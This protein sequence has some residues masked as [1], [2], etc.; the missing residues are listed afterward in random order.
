[1]EFDPDTVELRTGV[2]NPSSITLSDDDRKGRLARIVRELHAGRSHAEVAS[3]TGTTE[4][5]VAD[6]IQALLREE[7]LVPA[8]AGESA[9]APYLIARTLGMGMEDRAVPARAM[10][11]APTA[12]GLLLTGLLPSGLRDRVAH[13]DARLVEDLQS[14]DLFLDAD[15]LAQSDATERFETWKG[16]AVVVVWPELNPILLGNLNRL[17]H[18]VGFTLLPAAIDGPFAVLGPTVV[19]SV[20][21]CWACAETRVLDALRDHTL[22]V[23][24]RTALAD[25]RVQVS[26]AGEEMNPFLGL[27]AGLCA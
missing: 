23:D 9:R 5:E 21:S 4:D 26:E 13:A 25:G 11:V 27:L 8:P 10:L 2:W 15:G 19:P 24:Y 18:L 6:V 7:I 20:T 17:A 3:G 22:Y 16:A 14:R 12:L 1:V